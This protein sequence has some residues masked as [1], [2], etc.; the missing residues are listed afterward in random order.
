MR[1]PTMHKIEGIFTY[2]MG[3]KSY[4]EYMLLRYVCALL[5]QGCN[6]QINDVVNSFI[7]TSYW[8]EQEVPQ[9]GRPQ[10]PPADTN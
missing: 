8:H 6:K 3:K 5:L 10:A 1:R 9:G 2:K 4:I 7:A